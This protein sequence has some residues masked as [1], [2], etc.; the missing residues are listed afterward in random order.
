MTGVPGRIYTIAGGNSVRNIEMAHR[1]LKL[2]GT[3]GA[4]IR[5]AEVRVRAR[6]SHG[7]QWIR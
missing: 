5:H 7:T 3:S 4:G 2:A 1:V 6:L